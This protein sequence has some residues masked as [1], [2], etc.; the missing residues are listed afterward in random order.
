MGF[1]CDAINSY[2]VFKTLR[3]Q[4]LLPPEVRFQVSI[5]LV[6]S[7]IRKST[8]TVE[9]DLERI[10]PGYEEALK[11]EMQ[12]IISNIPNQDLAIQFDCSHEITDVNGGI[13]GEAIEGSIERNIGQ[14]QRLSSIIPQSVS[15]GLHLCFGTFGGWPRFAPTTLAPTVSFANAAI[16]AAGRRMDWV[17]IPTLD[18]IEDSFS[19]SA[20]IKT[21]TLLPL[22][23]SELER[24][25][26]YLKLFL[27]EN[28]V[29]VLLEGS[30]RV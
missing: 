27:T 10:R 25:L 17:N 9:G 24:I 23:R 22:N 26:I 19:V 1:A 13:P 8:F 5:P 21:Y 3:D 14:I 18:V 16:H 2:F 29:V 7:V 30:S 11:A 6:N 12:N 20:S 28:S 15:L 4:G